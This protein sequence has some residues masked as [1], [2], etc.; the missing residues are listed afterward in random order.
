MVSPFARVANHRR[1]LQDIPGLPQAEQFRWAALDDARK[2]N[3]DVIRRLIYEAL[4][5]FIVL[6]KG[7]ETF[8]GFGNALVMPY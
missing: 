1:T 7:N 4:P 6:L 5:L 8:L 2:R 3:G